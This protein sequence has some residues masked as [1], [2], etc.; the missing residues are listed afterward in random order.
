LSLALLPRIMDVIEA[1]GTLVAFPSQTT[2]VVGDSGLN[3]V[4]SREAIEKIQNWK[5][6]NELPFPDR[7]SRRVQ[8]DIEYP[9]AGPAAQEKGKVGMVEQA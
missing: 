8:R 5:D 2:Y 1:S 7:E 4:R 3:P 6:R 9:P